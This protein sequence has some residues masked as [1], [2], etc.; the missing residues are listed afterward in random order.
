MTDDTLET[1]RPKRD[2]PSTPKSEAKRDAIMAAAT[3]ILNARTYA[4]ATMNGIAAELKLRDGTLY[5]YF[6]SKQ[7]LFY[8]C[9]LRSIRRIERLLAVSEVEGA[10]GAAKLERFLFHLVY[11]PMREGPLLY[12]GDYF[13]LEAGQHAAISVAVNDLADKLEGFLRL[14]GVDGSIVECET[15]L[16]VRLL[17]GMLIWLPKWTSTIT[18]LTPERLLSAMGLFSLHGLKARA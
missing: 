1:A 4:L 3:S 13:H 18:D 12:L 16:V 11:D 6:P 2:R 8:A 5:Y 10:T 17:M 15:G 7:A 9:H 14:G